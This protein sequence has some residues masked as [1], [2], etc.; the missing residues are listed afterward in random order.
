[1]CGGSPFGTLPDVELPLGY[2]VAAFISPDYPHRDGLAYVSRAVL[3]R[4]VARFGLRD[5]R[6]VF[7]MFLVSEL[8]EGRSLTTSDEQKVFFRDAFAHVGG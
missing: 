7:F 1:M 8:S 6:T 4:Q 2:W 3:G 5:G